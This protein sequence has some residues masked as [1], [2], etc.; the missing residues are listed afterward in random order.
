MGEVTARIVTDDDDEITVQ[1]YPAAFVVTVNQGHS[2]P[3]KMPTYQFELT[4]AES[5]ALR[6]A[7]QLS[8]YE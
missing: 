8:A 6:N 1:R 4:D 3:G 7:L 5:A 2:E